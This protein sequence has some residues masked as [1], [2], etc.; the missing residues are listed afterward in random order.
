MARKPHTYH[1]IYKTINILNNKFY[2]GMHSTSNLDDGYLGSGTVI[3][4]A[5]KRYG[6][7]NFIIKILEFCESRDHLRIKESELITQDVINDPMCMNLRL[8]GDNGLGTFGKT[9]KKRAFKH[10]SESHKANLSKAGKGK[11]GKFVRTAETKEKI[12]QA[13]IGKTQSSETKEKRGES[14]K[15]FWQENPEAK[16]KKKESTLKGWETRRNRQKMLKETTI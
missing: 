2:L 15:K 9:L 1:Y 4:R 8:G 16:E 6:R 5:I 13:N 3:S 14:I 11:N 10:L 7:E 12:R